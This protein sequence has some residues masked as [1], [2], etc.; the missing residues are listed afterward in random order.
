[1]FAS[2]GYLHLQCCHLNCNSLQQTPH[3]MC[4]G[5]EGWRRGGMASDDSAP[6]CASKMSLIISIYPP[7]T[8]KNLAEP[9][10]P[11][12]PYGAK[13][14]PTPPSPISAVNRRV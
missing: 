13:I 2:Q 6:L 10:S 1:M 4:E 5:M 7:Q 11:H 9:S 3:L 14:I 12:T 8:S